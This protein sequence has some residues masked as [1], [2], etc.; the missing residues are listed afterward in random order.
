MK[1]LQRI[2]GE[3]LD[4]VLTYQEEKYGSK[5]MYVEYR[6]KNDENEPKID[7]MH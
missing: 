2:M 7:K 6:F 3:L 5:S 1:C 4:L